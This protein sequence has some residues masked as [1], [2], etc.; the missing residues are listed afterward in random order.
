MAASGI[1]ATAL[2]LIHRHIHSVGQLEVLL[3]CRAAPDKSWTPA[4]VARALVTE[5]ET[6]A[7]R[8]RDLAERGLLSA[9]AGE[10]NPYRYAPADARLE[11]AIDDLAEAYA[12]RRVTVVGLIFS[13]PDHGA[14]ALADAFRIRRSG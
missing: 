13:K 11:A 14:T 4:E 3:L 9:A 6:A 12:T 1:P 5:P 10:A 7:M 2:G 8:L